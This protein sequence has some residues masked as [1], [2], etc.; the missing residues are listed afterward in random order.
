MR[1]RDLIKEQPYSIGYLQ[2]TYAVEGHLQAGLVQNS[3]GK[4]AKGDSAGITAAAAATAT[5]MPDDFRT[6]ITNAADADAYPIASF[7]WILVPE[8]IDD[9]AKRLAIKAFLKWVL[10]D[11]QKF[12]TPLHYAPLPGDVASR[13]LKAVDRI[14]YRSVL[15]YSQRIEGKPS[16]SPARAA[17]S[18]LYAA[19]AGS[20]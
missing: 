10:T 17:L 18:F 7:T 1:V 4:F 8:H 20:E 9:Q 13:V 15:I 16:R 6:S 12:A 5:D 19:R 2:V 3:T 14:Q 11:G